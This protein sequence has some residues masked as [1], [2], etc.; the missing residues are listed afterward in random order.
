MLVALIYDQKETKLKHLLRIWR[1][2]KAKFVRLFFLLSLA[3]K[4]LQDLANTPVEQ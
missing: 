3:W 4:M 1:C 2:C